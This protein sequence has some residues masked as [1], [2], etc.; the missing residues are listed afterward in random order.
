[1]KIDKFLNL[2]SISR[3]SDSQEGSQSFIADTNFDS[4]LILCKKNLISAAIVLP[5]T[6]SSGGERMASDKILFPIENQVSLFVV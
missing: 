5:A 4:S 6:F 1:M 2:D 3:S